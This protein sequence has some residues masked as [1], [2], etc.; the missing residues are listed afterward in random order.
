MIEYKYDKAIQAE[1]LLSLYSD[2]GWTAYTSNLP[3][4]QRAVAASRLVI[5]A[6]EQDELISLVRVVGDGE[7]IAYI[8][9]VWSKQ[10]E[11]NKGIGKNSCDAFL[12]KSNTFAR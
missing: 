11:Q 9:D 8:Q 1:N 4:L 3:Q 7:T 12:K 2:A 5:S 10:P 6:W